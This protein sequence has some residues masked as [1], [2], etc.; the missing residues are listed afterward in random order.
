[1]IASCCGFFLAIDHESFSI[2]V[3]ALMYVSGYCTVQSWVWNELVILPCSGGQVILHM[4]TGVGFECWFEFYV[5]FLRFS[6]ETYR[7][8]TTEK[9]WRTSSLMKIRVY[10]VDCPP[11]VVVVVGGN[12]DSSRCFRRQRSD[13]YDNVPLSRRSVSRSCCPY[14]AASMRGVKPR[15][16]AVSVRAPLFRSSIARTP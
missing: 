3:R 16:V 14:I 7:K 5:H 11:F 13:I 10:S 8:I 15:P 6:A 4:F 9:A 2:T 1:M 12:N